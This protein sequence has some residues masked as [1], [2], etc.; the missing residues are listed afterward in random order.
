M[1]SGSSLGLDPDPVE[2]PQQRLGVGQELVCQQDRL[3]GLEVGL[4]RH[5][6]LGMGV[7]LG[8]EG[9][10]HVEYPL[11][12]GADGVPQP[13]AE[14]GGHLVIARAARPEAAPHLDPDPVDQAS[15][16]GTVDV[17]VGL[18]RDERPRCD[19]GR[20]PVQTVEH[21]VEVRTREQVRAVEHARVGL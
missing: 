12:H 19:V 6:R 1:A 16:E 2:I 7:R 15:F 3:G 18:R 21:R 17:L 13:H 14:Q 10:D 4:T 5:H 8:H 11:R 20:Q 9:I